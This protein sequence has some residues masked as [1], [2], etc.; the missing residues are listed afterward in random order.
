MP[1]TV[2]EASVRFS[3]APWE[4]V[5][6][7]SLNFDPAYAI[8]STYN[9]SNTLY[10]QSSAGSEQQTSLGPI[11]AGFHTY[12][13]DRQASSPTT[14][15]LSYYIDGVLR[16][17]HSVPTLP[18]MYVYQSHSGGTA[19]TLDIDRLW[20]YPN[21]V[22]SGSFQSCTFD[23][24]HTLSTWTAATWNASVP[25]GTGLQLRT[26][27]STNGTNWS[28]WSAPLTPS[29]QAVTSPA[30]RYLQYLLELVERD[31]RARARSSTP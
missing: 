16:A 9:T 13:I 17:Q 30:G 2:L 22:N 1:V 20:V 6:W 29:G 26:R 27:T 4:H 23:I 10:A 14:D 8:F 15:T 28:G 24:G 21:H 7:A 3:A 25:A 31:S 12:R 11:P 19:Q 18:S 5:G